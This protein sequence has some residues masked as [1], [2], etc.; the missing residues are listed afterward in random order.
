MRRQVLVASS[1]SFKATP[2][3]VLRETQFSVR[4]VRWRTVANLDSI[5]LVVRRCAQWSAGNR[6]RRPGPRDP[7]SA[8]RLPSDIWPRSVAGSARGPARRLWGGRHPDCPQGAFRLALQRLRQSRVHVAY[9][10][11]PAALM[12]RLGIDLLQRGPE[13]Q[14]AVADSQAWPPFRQRSLRSRRTSGRDAVDGGH[15]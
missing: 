10:V 11:E 3:K 6:R 2:R 7:W 15:L 14:R 9:L 13:A 1:A 8:S 5:G 4:V 12:C